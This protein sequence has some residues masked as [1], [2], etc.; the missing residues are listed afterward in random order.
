[1]KTYTIKQIRISVNNVPMP[2]RQVQIEV[3]DLEEI[4]QDELYRAKKMHEIQNDADI[5]IDFVIVEE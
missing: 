1:M 5:A 3:T 4:R 2:A